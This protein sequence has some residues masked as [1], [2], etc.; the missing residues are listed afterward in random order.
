MSSRT[1]DSVEFQLLKSS[2]LGKRL[3]YFRNEMKVLQP[4]IDYTTSAIA[5][6]IGAS[7]QTITAVERGDSKKPSFY[8]VSQLTKEYGVPLDAVTDEFYHF[9]DNLFSIGSPDTVHVDFDMDDIEFNSAPEKGLGMVLY[10]KKGEDMIRLLHHDEINNIK[11][12]VDIVQLLSRFMYEI[13][14][15]NTG[16]SLNLSDLFNKKSP[17]EYATNIYRISER[18]HPYFSKNTLQ[19]FITVMTNGKDDNN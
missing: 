1:I 13:E 16:N 2:S 12:D 7:P 5:K 17:F 8:L 10:E 14:M 11:N 9:E 4:K 6:R 18:S 3:K 19:K 15:H